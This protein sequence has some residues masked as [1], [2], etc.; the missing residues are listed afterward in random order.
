MN[1]TKIHG[2]PYDWVGGAQL[3]WLI[4]VVHFQVDSSQDLLYIFDMYISV[5]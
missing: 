5:T 1:S 4:E 3:N 2:K